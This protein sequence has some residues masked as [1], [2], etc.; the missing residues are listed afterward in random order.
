LGTVTA[1]NGLTMIN[2][3]VQLGGLMTKSDTILNGTSGNYRL[4]MQGTTNTQLLRLDQAG[5]GGGILVNQTNTG[6]V[7]VVFAVSSTGTGSNPIVQVT[8]NTPTSLN[9][10]NT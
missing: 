6:S 8:G 9:A 7:G 10:R 1:S 5:T 2:N 3:D 4:N